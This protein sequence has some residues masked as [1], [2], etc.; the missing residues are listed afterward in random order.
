MIRSAKRGLVSTSCSAV[1]RSNRSSVE[2]STAVAVAVRGAP[3]K[4]ET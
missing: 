2:S 4:Q 1:L 3:P